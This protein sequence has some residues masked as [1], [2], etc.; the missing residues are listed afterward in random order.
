MKRPVDSKFP[1]SSPFGPRVDPKTKEPN[2]FHKGV[3]FACPVGTPC[4]ACFDGY[5]GYIR[6]KADGNGAG[7]RLG[8]YNSK[9][10]ALYF[11]LMDDSFFVKPGEKVVAGQLLAQTGDTG[12]STGPHLHFQLEDLKS[13][14][15]IEPV[16]EDESHAT[17]VA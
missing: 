12:K 17:A 14:Q 5:V 11:H 9:R 15:P 3:D 7:N 16:F 10:R 6:L 8:L 13:L 2:V 1:I 4:I